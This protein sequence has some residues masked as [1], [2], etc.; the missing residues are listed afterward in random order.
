VAR[1][2]CGLKSMDGWDGQGVFEVYA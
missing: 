1:G 2:L